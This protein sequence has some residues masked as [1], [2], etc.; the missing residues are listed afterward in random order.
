MTNTKLLREK[1]DASGLKLNY[2]ASQLWISPKALTM[3]IE[4]Q[5]QFKAAEIKRLSEILGIETAEE[6]E[7]IFLIYRRPHWQEATKLRILL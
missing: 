4:N 5:T 7:Q 6:R 1:I 3:K 2:I